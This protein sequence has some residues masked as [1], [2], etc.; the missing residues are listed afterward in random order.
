VTWRPATYEEVLPLLREGHLL[1]VKPV[2]A[3][4]FM[5]TLGRGCCGISYVGHTATLRGAFVRVAYR[6]MGIGQSG[7]QLRLERLGAAAVVRV[8]A[9]SADRVPFWQARGFKV[10]RS[11]KNG[12]VLLERRPA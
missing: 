1:T 10:L 2:R 11:F 7:V 3:D 9:K 5:D 4:W 12:A 8:Y 6:G